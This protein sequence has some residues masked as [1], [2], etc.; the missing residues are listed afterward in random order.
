[1]IQGAGPEEIKK[2]NFDASSPGG[3]FFIALPQER[4]ILG[5]LAGIF[6]FPIY[7]I[8]NLK[9]EYGDVCRGSQKKKFVNQ[10]HQPDYL[11]PPDQ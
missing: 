8:P 4:K 1:M 2:K 11:R 9:P 5:T 6:F 3:N 10:P 7:I